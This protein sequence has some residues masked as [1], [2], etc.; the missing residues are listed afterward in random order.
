MKLRAQRRQSGHKLDHWRSWRVVHASTGCGPTTR[1]GGSVTSVERVGEQS[2]EQHHRY[3]GLFGSEPVNGDGFAELHTSIRELGQ[4]ASDVHAYLARVEFT[5]AAEAG[6]AAALRGDRDAFGEAAA[7]ASA[8]AAAAD[9]SAQLNIRGAAA[10][11]AHME[12][13]AARLSVI[14][15]KDSPEGVMQ[16]LATIDTH[17]AKS[18]STVE[19]F[20]ATAQ[21]LGQFAQMAGTHA[22]PTPPQLS[23]IAEN[24]PFAALA[25]SAPIT[26]LEQ[27]SQPSATPPAHPES[28]DRPSAPPGESQE[29]P[30]PSIDH[31]R[32]VASHDPSPGA[33]AAIE[34]QDQPVA[35]SGPR[36]PDSAAAGSD[37]RPNADV[38]CA[39]PHR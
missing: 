29:T 39:G 26:G 24:Y 7:I 14:P 27:L 25:Q 18:L 36:H 20:A 13:E 28:Q 1:V 5:S 6:L 12:G 23:Q 32:D 10:I 4:Q 3:Y 35:V 21:D 22:I 33:P 16:T 31:R 30:S 8:A 38:K 9:G 2:R 11:A 37:G 34:Y 19:Q 17:Q 15:D